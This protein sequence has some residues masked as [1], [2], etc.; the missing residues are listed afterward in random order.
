MTNCNR[1]PPVFPSTFRGDYKANFRPQFIRSHVESAQPAVSTPLSISFTTSAVRQVIFSL[2]QFIFRFRFRFHC[3]FCNST[4]TAD[5]R[6]CLY[7]FVLA[8]FL[9][10]FFF[11]KWPVH[12]HYHQRRSSCH[13]LFSNAATLGPLPAATHIQFQPIPTPRK[14]KPVIK[15]FRNASTSRFIQQAAQNGLVQTN[16]HFNTRNNTDNKYVD[17]ALVFPHEETS[18]HLYI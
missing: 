11:S 2:F 8:F 16:T 18:L 9:T 1:Q 3:K 15:N 4:K 14:I 12:S 10:N 6:E 17:F 13:H 5:R 7:R